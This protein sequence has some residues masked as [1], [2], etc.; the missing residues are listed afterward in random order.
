MAMLLLLLLVL[1]EWWKL[2][3]SGM[4]SIVFVVLVQLSTVAMECVL[5][6]RLATNRR[7]VALDDEEV[8]AQDWSVRKRL[9][10]GVHVARAA[11]VDEATV[12]CGSLRTRSSC[13]WTLVRREWRH[14]RH[15]RRIWI[16]LCR[17]LFHLVTAA[18][19]ASR[20]GR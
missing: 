5:P 10:Y 12:T 19:H 3:V 2:R 6:P 14:C 11:H 20:C 9:E 1:I 13:V 18:T 17:S 15:F 8:V 7:A 16:L 4:S